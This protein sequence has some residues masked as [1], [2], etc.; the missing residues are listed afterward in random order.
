MV[1][2]MF[3]PGV[4]TFKAVAQGASKVEFKRVELKQLETRPQLSFS[5]AKKEL[6]ALLQNV[7]YA[8]NHP[9]EAIQVSDEGFSWSL[10]S[11]GY[12]VRFEDL[13]NFHWRTGGGIFGVQFESRSRQN[14]L[15][16][17]FQWTKQA[18]RDRF[19]DVIAALRYYFYARPFED[20]QEKAKAWRALSAKPPLP[21]EVQ[22]FRVLAEDAFQNK[23][24]EKA[25]GY[26]EKGLAIEPMWP[27]GQFNAALLSAELEHYGKA[28]R[29][30]KR[31]LELCPDDK[32]ARAAR[33]KM[34]VW[35]EKTKEEK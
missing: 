33:E 20:F 24:F 31:Y 29:H 2:V 9:L 26:Y 22:R 35:E 5:D 1:V 15:C 4:V 18:D 7:R 34:Y 13:G 27:A 6:L 19:M 21:E 14:R 30:I 12:S 25:V 8:E 28:T 23:N 10:M 32:E 16:L 3:S 17:I 11:K